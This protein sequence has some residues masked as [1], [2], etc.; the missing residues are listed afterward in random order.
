[1]R[2]AVERRRPRNEEDRPTRG[3]K[4]DTETP[5]ATQGRKT[6]TADRT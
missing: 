3:D 2:K 4:S 5:P 1:M 6:A